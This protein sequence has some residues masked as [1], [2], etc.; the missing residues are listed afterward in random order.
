IKMM[1][2]VLIKILKTRVRVLDQG[3]KNYF[4]GIGRKQMYE[5]EDKGPNFTGSFF[6]RTCV[7]YS[8]PLG[9]ES[10]PGE[11]TKRV[12]GFDGPRPTVISYL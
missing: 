6:S 3:N 5:V 1:L 12:R 9:A 11:C 8:F 10:I 7:L 2:T 4:E